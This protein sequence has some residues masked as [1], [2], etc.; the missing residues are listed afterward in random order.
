MDDHHRCPTFPRH[1]HKFVY[2]CHGNGHVLTVPVVVYASRAGKNTG[3]KNGFGDAYN[4]IERIQMCGFCMQELILSGLYIWKALDIL[5]ADEQK[6]S[7]R[8]MWQ[9]FAINVII[10]M[11]DVALLTFEFRSLHVIQQT[12]K[13]LVYSV[14]LKLEL[15]ILSK[16]VEL[17][18]SNARV[19][20]ITFGDTNEFL[21]PT[22]T[23]WDITRFT[24]AFS[25]TTYTYPKWKSDLERSGL[26]RVESAY[27]PTDSTWVN[28]R[29]VK[30]PTTEHTE[31][32]PD[33][34]QPDHTNQDPRHDIRERGSDTDLLYADAVRKI[35]TPG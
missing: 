33:S 28:A 25:S 3:I 35:S 22:K 17:S 24:P 18:C 9:L 11:L 5:R 19:S 31:Y 8:L 30:V 14:K 15:A 21:D 7:H 32:F 1:H 16:L 2:L 6:R 26:Q 27:S 10:V 20:A 34:I 29:Q 13:S 4:V 23:V 12:V